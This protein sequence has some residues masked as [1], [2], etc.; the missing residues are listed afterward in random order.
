LFTIKRLF[1]KTA[2]VLLLFFVAFSL[3]TNQVFAAASDVD[4]DGVLNAVDNCQTTANANQADTDND[5]LGDACDA[6][7]STDVDEDGVL[8]ANDNCPFVSNASQTDTDSDNIGNSCDLVDDLDVDGDTVSNTADNCQEDVNATQ[9][10]G[11]SDGLGDACDPFPAVSD[12]DE[13]NDGV[14]NSID[15][16]QL[17]AN[18]AQ[19]D[20]DFDGL[21][22]ACDPTDSRDYDGDLVLNDA[23]N[24]VVTENIGQ[25]DSDVDGL[26]DDCDLTNN[27]DPDGDGTESE[28][29]NCDLVSNPDQADSDNDGLGNACDTTSDDD[30]DDN[31]ADDVDNCPTISNSNQADGNNNGTGD[32]CEAGGGL[33]PVAFE[34]PTGPFGIKIN[35]GALVTNSP[36]V[37]LT[38]FFGSNVERMALGNNNTNLIHTG[39]ESVVGVKKWNLCWQ[40]SM[41]QT[42]NTCAPGTYTVT[43]Q[44]F[45]GWGQ[46]SEL[47]STTINY[48]PD[49]SPATLI[50]NGLILDKGTVYLISSSKKYG[51]TTMP[52]FSGLGYSL[53][54]V[55]RGDASL[56]AYGGILDRPN[57]PHVV[58][59]W[60]LSNKTVYYVSVEGLIPIPTWDIFVA[61]SGG[62][63]IVQANESDLAKPILPIMVKDDPRV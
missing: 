5:S 63:I 23:D 41:F 42:P 54:Q 30:D 16:C 29:D 39:Q 44:F 37:E 17:D 12:L 1:S 40:Y 59:S 56:Y 47:I 35:K 3:N 38:M 14:I 31:V 49:A 2:I 61:N 9:T 10:D 50:S 13:D 19:L 62:S 8:N 32:S 60:I 58:G 28:D 24:C 4:S 33:P 36:D 43:A 21:G 48:N 11:E 18:I 53:K 20:S 55:K 7:A 26:G 46:E 22:N 6:T 57:M 25:D 45:T 51:F 27:Y 15:N 34:R 52:V